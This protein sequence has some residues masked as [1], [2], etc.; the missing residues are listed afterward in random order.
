MGDESKPEFS[1]R[2]LDPN[3]LTYAFHAGEKFDTQEGLNT[4]HGLTKAAADFNITYEYGVVPQYDHPFTVGLS[5]E[6]APV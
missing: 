5:I 3:R 2:Y 6:P 4:T 1:R